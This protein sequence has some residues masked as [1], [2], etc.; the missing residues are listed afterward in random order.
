VR[1]AA[2]VGLSVAAVTA[3]GI[4]ASAPTAGA[5]PSIYDPEITQC[6]QLFRTPFE[7]AP[8][9]NTYWSP[10]GTA[11]IVCYDNGTGLADF[12][13][14]DPMGAWHD[15]NEIVPGNFFYSILATTVPDRAHWR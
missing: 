9:T 8:G 12:Y 7:T 2:R 1:A 5:T 11:N 6:S 10:F 4:I 13:Q 3:G 14:R 15:M